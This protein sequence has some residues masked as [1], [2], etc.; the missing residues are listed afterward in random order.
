MHSVF[1]PQN[2]KNRIMNKFVTELELLSGIVIRSRIIKSLTCVCVFVC[3]INFFTTAHTLCYITANLNRLIA[4][5]IH[6]GICIH[7]IKA[8][9]SVK[10]MKLQSAK[11]S[12]VL[13]HYSIFILAVWYTTTSLDFQ[14]VTIV[15]LFINAPPSNLCNLLHLL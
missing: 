14:P 5:R 9:S 11:Y 4:L 1:L 8:S 7:L 2:F 15:R 10:L 3:S 6:T 12:L 13:F